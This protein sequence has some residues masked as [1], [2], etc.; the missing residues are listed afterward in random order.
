M[1]KLHKIWLKTQTLTQFN[2]AKWSQKCN[3]SASNP[4]KKWETRGFCGTE[5]RSRRDENTTANNISND[6]R[7]CTQVAHF[8]PEVETACRRSAKNWNR[9]HIGTEKQ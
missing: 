6:I 3:Q 1:L 2:V 5:Y 4:D 7:C 9:D 8:W